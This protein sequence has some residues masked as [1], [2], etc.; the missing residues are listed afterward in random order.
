MNDDVN[1]RLRVT[2]EEYEPDRDRMWT[3]VS[4]GMR[5]PRV[6]AETVRT[7]WRI[8]QLGLATGAALALIGVIV[9]FGQFLGF[10]PVVGPTPEPP[11]AGPGTRSAEA[12]DP[13]SSGDA[14]TGGE[15]TSADDSGGD[16]PDGSQSEDGASEGASSP[17]IPEGP[18]W[19]WTDGSL[20]PDSD[21]EFWSQLDLKVRSEEP[22][23]EL[24]VE[25]RV[26]EGAGV[27][28]TGAWTTGDTWFNAAVVTREDGFLVYRWSLKDDAVLPA[29]EYTLAGQ[30][31]HNAGT[32]SVD[33]DRFTF[34]AE[35]EGGE[36]GASEGDFK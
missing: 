33:E 26:A 7:G 20:N 12:T 17:E 31:N 10:G 29:G 5:E 18:A 25:L 30:F 14:A 1:D 2:A 8:P 15:E 9:F 28:S 13:A 35:T 6:R 16:E 19:L 21:E 11:A 24:N 3:R 34:E 4:E 23:T 22:L 32:R 36:A 27:E